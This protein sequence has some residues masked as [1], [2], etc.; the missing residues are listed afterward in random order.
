MMPDKH[1][2]RA[3]MLTALGLPETR[4]LLMRIMAQSN[5]LGLSYA[6]GDAL[7]TAHNEGLRRVGLWL[8]AEIDQADPEAFARMLAEEF[9]YLKPQ[10]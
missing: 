4:R 2:A 10:V 3:D 8:K 5:I 7:A 1:Q 9:K 6:A